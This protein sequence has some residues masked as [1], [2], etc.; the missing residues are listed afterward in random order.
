MTASNKQSGKFTDLDMVGFT[1]VPDPAFVIPRLLSAIFG[2]RNTTTVPLPPY[3]LENRE[4][5]GPS[6][7]DQTEFRNLVDAEEL[8]ALP[9]TPAKPAPELWLD[10][11]G[12]VH[13]EPHQD[14]REKLTALSENH[15]VL[16]QEAF[17]AKSWLKARRHAKMAYSA[18]PKRLEPLVIRAAVECRMGWRAT[19]TGKAAKLKRSIVQSGNVE[20]DHGGYSTGPPSTSS[21]GSTTRWIQR[22]SR[23]T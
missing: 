23:L 7:C 22:V 21:S 13:Y 3:T 16:A 4:V 8:S 19:L 18:N 5:V 14:A 20:L 11:K 15:M 1:E 9:T 6:R 17:R 10:D 12:S 2:V